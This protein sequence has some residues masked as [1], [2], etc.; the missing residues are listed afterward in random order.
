[1]VNPDETW[2]IVINLM[3]RKDAV[4][5]YTH[6]PFDQYDKMILPHDPE[7]L[8]IRKDNYQN[9]SREA[10]EIIQTILESPKEVLSLITTSKLGLFSKRVLKKYLMKKGWRE[11]EVNEVFTELSVYVNGLRG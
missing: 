10:Q 5:D 2:L 6:V 3:Y 9:L 8:L 7:E 1:M 11:K 4:M